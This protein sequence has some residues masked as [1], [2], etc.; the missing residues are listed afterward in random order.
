MPSGALPPEPSDVVIVTESKEATTGSDS[1][2]SPPFSPITPVMSNDFPPQ[3]TPHNDA[4]PTLE[5]PPLQPFS[6]SD[7]PDAIALRSAIAILQLQRQQTL[8]DLVSLE[9]QKKLAVASPEGFAK[10]VAT[11]EIKTRSTGPLG[12]PTGFA[13]PQSQSADDGNEEQQASGTQTRDNAVHS[14]FE[15]IPAPQSIVRC[16][17][18]NWAKY[19]VLGQPLDDLHEEQRRRPVD[20][21][22]KQNDAPARGEE[23]VIAA[24]YNPFKDRLE[25]STKQTDSTPEANHNNG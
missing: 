3:N 11:G 15:D 7:N 21:H 20:G 2:T 17:P 25:P 12:F 19:H 9:R 5:V 8:R 14:A 24:P 4:A 22:G 10:A 6:E 1:P 18:V 13:P 16:P 23:H